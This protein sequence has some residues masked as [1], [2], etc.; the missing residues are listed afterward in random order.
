M[1]DH[2]HRTTWSKSPIC[3]FA[4]NLQRL[5]NVI[6]IYNVNSFSLIRTRLLR[7]FS[8]RRCSSHCTCSPFSCAVGTF[9]QNYN[10]NTEKP[11]KIFAFFT[12]TKSLIN[13]RILRVVSVHLPVKYFKIFY[14]SV[15]SRPHNF[16]MSQRY[17]LT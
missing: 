4:C 10:P 14:N 16:P 8:R 1:L 7:K 6:A 15:L 17:C 11:K 13:T 3:L 12:H 9:H 5:L 2:F